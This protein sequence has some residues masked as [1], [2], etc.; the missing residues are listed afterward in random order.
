MNLSSALLSFSICG[1]RYE[2]HILF[3][4][5]LEARGSKNKR[6]LSVMSGLAPFSG[7]FYMGAGGGTIASGRP[8]ADPTKIQ[9]WK[10]ESV[11]IRPRE[12]VYLE[13]GTFRQ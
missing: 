10:H 12:N 8:S 3:Q 13:P 1:E 5:A 11:E 4:N 2:I 6:S 7:P 9:N